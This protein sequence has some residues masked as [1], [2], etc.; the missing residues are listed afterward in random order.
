VSI[1][2]SGSHTVPPGEPTA[3]TSRAG[4]AP[5]TRWIVGVLALLILLPAAALAAAALLLPSETIAR[6]AAARGEA[7]LGVPLRI[8]DVEIDLLPI[9]SV[10]LLELRLGEEGRAIA[11]ADR[12]LLRPRLLPLLRGQVTVRE[13][14]IERPDIRL[15][16]D[17]NGVL[18]LP[19]SGGEADETA[20]G[21]NVGFAVDELRVHD[22]RLVY[23]DLRDGTRV[24]LS[25]LNQRLRIDGRVV[26]GELARVGLAGTLSSDSVDAELPARLNAPLRGVR[27]AVTHEAELDREADRLEVGALRLELQR[28]A[29]EGSGTI[30]AV[31]DSLARTLSLRLQT[32]EFSFEDLAR[33]IPEGFLAEFLAGHGADSSIA[34]VEEAPPAAEPEMAYAG[35]AVIET[36]IDGL[37]TRDSLPRI[38]GEAR[39]SGVGVQRA[40]SDLL[41]GAVGTVSFTNDGVEGREVE[42]RLL[43]EPFTLAFRVDDLAA[44]AASFAARGVARVAELLALVESEE[45]IRG[46]GSVPFDLRGT[47]R[48]DDPASSEVEGTVGLGGVQLALPS[49]L[50]PV[51][52]ESGTLR[53]AGTELRI[54]DVAAAFGESRVR[55]SG[56]ADG[57]LRAVLADSSELPVLRFDARA[58]ALDL[59]ALLGPSESQYAPLLF[60]RLAERPVNGKSAAEAAR[61]AGLTLPELPRIRAEGTLHANRLVRNGVT[62][63][64]VEAAF[65]SSPSALSV[66][67]VSFGMMGGNVELGLALERGEREATLVAV[68]HLENVG[69]EAF[70]SRFT[71]FTGNLS[72]MLTLDGEAS[73]QLDEQFLPV[74]PTVQSSGSLALTS[75]S[76][77]GWPLLGAVGAKLGLATFDTLAFREWSGRFQVAGPLVRLERSLQVA[78]RVET[79]LAGSFDWAG[80]L[81]LGVVARLSP[82]L[83]ARA[84]EPIRVAAQA[85]AGEEGSVPVGIRITGTTAAPNVTLDLTTARNNA[86]AQA[87]VRAEAEAESAARRAA[88]EVV[89]RTLGDSVTVSPEAVGEVLRSRVQDRLRGLF[90]GGGAADADSAAAEEDSV[91]G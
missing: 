75:G 51:R 17:E 41:A 46:S 91:T 50:Q 22:G 86:L 71:T 11:A 36:R 69:A 31:S 48:P 61:D 84:A 87:R 3:R 14:T 7:A 66:P 56:V 40:G 74:R 79:E 20:G 24:T 8:A 90:G 6:A 83:V 85:A 82:E 5:L 2:A 39:F 81:D 29:L 72:G 63:E 26:R 52:L 54:E 10:A 89:E 76:L 16:V 88:A 25:A 55:V 27:F 28:V 13:I 1:D 34:V 68:Y 60:A 64:E 44:P 77:A 67:R 4:R 23:A 33:S 18:N 70:F 65:E 35:R 12:L 80:K 15:V 47:L 62:Y 78:D 30:D 43:G 57:W 21:S 45:P 73:L 49:L 19:F 37:V 53:L 42:G 38:V 59:D 9:P 32:D 58:A